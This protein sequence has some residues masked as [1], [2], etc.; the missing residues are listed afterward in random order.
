M[1]KMEQSFMEPVRK[2]NLGKIKWKIESPFIYLQTK[3]ETLLLKEGI[4][5]I[6]N[7]FFTR[8]SINIGNFNTV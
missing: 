7:R 8:T 5:F 6:H 1:A 2:T 3:I 4:S